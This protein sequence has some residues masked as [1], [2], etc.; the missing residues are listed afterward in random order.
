MKTLYRF[1]FCCLLFSV[2]TV[3]AQTD[4]L[5]KKSSWSV[6]EDGPIMYQFEPNYAAVQ[7]KRRMAL[8]Q[9]IRALDTLDISEKKRLR[10]IKALYKDLNSEKVQ[11]TILADTQFEEEE[12]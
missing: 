1:A 3:H 9:K 4:S 12:F 5:Q 7:L 2:A 8:L 6:E 11:K 10:L